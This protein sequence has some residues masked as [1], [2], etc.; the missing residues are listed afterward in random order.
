MLNAGYYELSDFIFLNPRWLVAAVGS[1]LRHDLSTEL[2]EVRRA[3]RNL[4]N[5]DETQC[6]SVASLVTQLRT[7]VNYPVI[8]A[9]DAYMLW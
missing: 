2:Y 1:I 3:L 5:L 7:D 4:D 8:S 6:S 9:R